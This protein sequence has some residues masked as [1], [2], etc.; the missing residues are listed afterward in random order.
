MHWG[1]NFLVFFAK[2]KSNLNLS[3]TKL[4]GRSFEGLDWPGFFQ[5]ISIIKDKGSECFGLKETKK[6]WQLDP[7]LNS[8]YQNNKQKKSIKVLLC[9]EVG[10]WQFTKGP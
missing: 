6:T 8:D 3:M 7:E 2:K 1:D 10:Q 4:L 9:K 5:N